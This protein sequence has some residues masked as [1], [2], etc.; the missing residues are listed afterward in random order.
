MFNMEYKHLLNLSVENALDSISEIFNACARNSLETCTVRSPDGRIRA[1]IPTVSCISRSPLS[2]NPPSAP[3]IS[4]STFF[5]S[6]GHILPPL[7]EK[8]K[9]TTTT[10]HGTCNRNTCSMRR[11]INSIFRWN[12]SNRASNTSARG[13]PKYRM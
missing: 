8:K 10:K 1:H 13:T 4:L 5:L 9:K 11:S 12:R 3:A 2:R 7:F 6:A